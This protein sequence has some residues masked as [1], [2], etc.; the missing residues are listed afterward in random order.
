MGLFNRNKVSKD[1]EEKETLADNARDFKRNIVNK[2]GTEQQG[3]EFEENID[4]EVYNTSLGI[5]KGLSY[6]FKNLQKNHI[7]IL[8]EC[9]LENTAIEL[10]KI[11]TRTNKSKFKNDILSPL[12]NSGFLEPTIPEKPNSP[13]QKYRLTGKFV[14]KI[15]KN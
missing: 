14:A 1:S 12:I 8:K 9:E 5:K 13:K 3:F 15:S 6:N 2:T 11:L 7:K 10:M 4:T